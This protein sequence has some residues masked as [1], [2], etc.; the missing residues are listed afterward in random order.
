MVQMYVKSC[1]I[2]V[3]SPKHANSNVSFSELLWNSVF[4]SSTENINSNKY[5]L[6]NILRA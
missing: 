1:E 3:F 6:A 5:K 2:S 4:I